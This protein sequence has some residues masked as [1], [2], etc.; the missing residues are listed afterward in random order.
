MNFVDRFD[1]PRLAPDHNLRDR[2]LRGESLF[3]TEGRVVTLRLLRSD[4]EADSIPVAEP[5]DRFHDVA[6][7]YR[8]EVACKF[9]WPARPICWPTCDRSD[10]NTASNWSRRSLI[11]RRSGWLRHAGCRERRWC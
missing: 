5:F 4:Y 7:E 2:T 11:R 8:R 6:G 9:P 1:D 3:I 10:G